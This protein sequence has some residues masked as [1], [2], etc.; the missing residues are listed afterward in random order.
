MSREET[1]HSMS[2][3]DLLLSGLGAVAVLVVLFA[4]IRTLNSQAG[5]TRAANMIIFELKNGPS[6]L[7]FGRDVGVVVHYGA[8]VLKFNGFGASDETPDGKWISSSPDRRLRLRLKSGSP[9]ARVVF[10]LRRA[11]GG[12][13]L[14]ATII[15]SRIN[16]LANFAKSGDLLTI[17]IS[18]TSQSGAPTTTCHLIIKGDCLSEATISVPGTP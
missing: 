6:D 13:S 17:E 12:A 18:S 10:W 3:L 16:Q 2:M 1:D 9:E 11:D 14:P 7:L 5:G 8:S 15:A 4:A